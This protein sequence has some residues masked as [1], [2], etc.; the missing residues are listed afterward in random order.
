MKS[1]SKTKEFVPRQTAVANLYK[2]NLRLQKLCVAH[3]KQIRGMANTL[4]LYK[5]IIEKGIQDEKIRDLE[6]Y[7]HNEKIKAIQERTAKTFGAPTPMAKEAFRIPMTQE[8]LAEAAYQ[9]DT[10]HEQ[11]DEEHA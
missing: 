7:I 8:E 1:G 3:R 11:F 6:A 9:A 2:E 10:P 5:L 4:R